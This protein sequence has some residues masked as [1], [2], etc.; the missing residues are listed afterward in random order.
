MRTFKVLLV[1]RIS[2]SLTKFKES[3]TIST[4]DYVQQWL[5]KEVELYKSNF[6]NNEKV[7]NKFMCILVLA[8]C[9]L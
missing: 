5:R 4:E 6:I 1:L 3:S 8:F 2:I 9:S 7:H